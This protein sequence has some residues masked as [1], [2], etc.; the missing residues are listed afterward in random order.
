MHDALVHGPRSSD[1]IMIDFDLKSCMRPRSLSNI[2]N[3]YRHSTLILSNSRANIVSVTRHGLCSELQI[4]ALTYVGKSTAPTPYLISFFCSHRS[5]HCFS[6]CALIF[7]TL[8]D[9]TCSWP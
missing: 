6:A 5:S 1:V 3:F 9:G 7:L 4:I 2:E 8:Y